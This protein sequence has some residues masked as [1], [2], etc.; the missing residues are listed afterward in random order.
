[1]KQPL[2]VWKKPSRA[3][4]SAEAA[5]ALALGDLHELKTS[6]GKQI[7]WAGESQIENARPAAL[8][9]IYGRLNSFTQPD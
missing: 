4:L 7:H 6:I 5:N 8:R 1:L 3:N 2:A 9:E